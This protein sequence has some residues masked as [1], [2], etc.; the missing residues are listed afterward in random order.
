MKEQLTV[1]YRRPADA[2]NAKTRVAT[3]AAAERPT[4]VARGTPPPETIVRS[5]V[6]L[7]DAPT[8]VR[9]SSPAFD[10]PTTM[11]QVD[12]PT[13]MRKALVE[14]PTTV[15]PN[16]PVFDPPTT[17]HPSTVAEGPTMVRREPIIEPPTTVRRVAPPNAPTAVMP[18]PS[19]SPSV[20]LSPSV[21]ASIQQPMQQPTQRQPQPQPQQQR[22][23]QQ[24]QA[25]QKRQAPRLPVVATDRPEVFALIRRIVMQ[26][27]LASAAG[28][29]HVELGALLGA[30]VVLALVGANREISCPLTTDLRAAASTVEL[31]QIAGC[32]EHKRPFGQ[33]RVLMVPLETQRTTVLVA[34][35]ANDAQPFDQATQQLMLAV[36]SRLDVLDHVLSLDNSQR[37]QDDAD[38]KSIFRPEALQAS[39]DPQR[40]GELVHLA[41]RIVRIAIPAV[42]VLAVTLVVAA[43][44]VQVPTYTRGSVVVSMNGRNVLSDGG[45]RVSAVHVTAGQMVAAGDPLLTLDA[46]REKQE[47]EQIE[48]VYRDQLSAFLFDPTDEG[49]RQSLA[50]VLVQRKGAQD[51]LDLMTVRAPI[52]GRVSSVLTSDL[53]QQGEQIATITPIDSEASVVAF[54]PGS[55][56]S[57]LQVGM[58]LQVELTGY[59]GTRTELVI[60]EVGT[61]VVG[62]STARKLLGQKLAD[63]VALPPLVVIVKATLPGPTFEAD[64]KTYSYFD[65][66]DGLAEIEVESK[67]FLSVI[68]PT[69]D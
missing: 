66:M 50:G 19:S 14:P 5:R 3:P 24:A 31:A 32:A 11:R 45:G 56:R 40:A 30:R 43:A 46:A 67:S 65:G 64:G 61:E 15:R 18:P 13:T 48:T 26:R 63:G 22:Q 38:R 1:A 41:P 20:E 7:P 21:V 68:L 8:V 6:A 57:R 62:A 17:I 9:S 51:R 27:D 58:K 47:L 28:L 34:Y 69:G 2:D 16:A 10:P 44:L 52:A 49:A 35:R 29:L 60:T 39:R 54:M 42:L 33:P 36:A 53:V 59:S 4:R 37:A 12:A 25:Q 55:D 23:P